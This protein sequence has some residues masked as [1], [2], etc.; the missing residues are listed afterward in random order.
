MTTTTVM[1][2]P[3]GGHHG[4]TAILTWGII[5][6]LA[7]GVVYTGIS[8]YD[9]LISAPAQSALPYI[10]LGIALL[11]AL[12]FEMCNGFHDTS[13]A[14][15]TVIYTHSL[16]PNVAVVWSGMFN[17]IGVLTSSGWS[18]LASFRCCRSS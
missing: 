11:I 16:A 1:E 5:A 3:L 12:A 13:N 7:I 10:L 18:P 17:F 8:L 2:S 14:V 6:L 9:D 4:S 15:A